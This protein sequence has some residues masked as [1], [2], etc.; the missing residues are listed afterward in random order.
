MGGPHACHPL[1]V[2][3]APDVSLSSYPAWDR[4]AQPCTLHQ[5]TSRAAR[6]VGTTEPGF[7]AQRV[8][9]EVPGP[10]PKPLDVMGTWVQLPMGWQCP[11]CRCL[12][13]RPRK[14]LGLGTCLCCS[15]CAALPRVQCHNKHVSPPPPRVTAAC[16]AAVIPQ[17]DW[18]QVPRGST[19]PPA[20]PSWKQ[21]AG[22]GILSATSGWSQCPRC[23]CTVGFAF[24]LEER[25]I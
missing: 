5:G 16:S 4:A 10:G 19:P 23:C 25:R 9:A 18:G 21:Q 24:P 15:C 13:C 11:C 14:A 8:A 22:Q 12:C 7:W 6:S 3:C 1:P 2:Q 17:G 20:P